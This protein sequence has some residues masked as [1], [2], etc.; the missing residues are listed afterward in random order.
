MNPQLLSASAVEPPPNHQTLVP[1]TPV[2]Q[3]GEA[4]ADLA[5]RIHAATYELLVMLREFDAQS[6]WNNG[7]MSC[8]HWLHWRTGI[9]L[10]AAREKVR[11]AKAVAQ[12][13]LLSGALQRGEI[14]YAKVRA[15]TRVATPENEARL[16]H[17]AYAG[18]AA[19]VERL[20][21][22]WRRCDRIMEERQ[23]ERA[24]LSRTVTTYVDED[25]MVVFRARLTPEL[26]AVVQRALEAAS[27]RLFQ[28]SRH[29]AAPES[30]TEEITSAQRRA[31]A[32]ALLAESALDNGLDRGTS[33][34]RYQVVMHVEG[35]VDA[36]VEQAVLE[37][38]DGGIHV[39]AETSRRLSCDAALVVMRESPDGSVLDVGRKTRTIPTAIRRALDARDQ[40]CRFPGCTASRCDAHHIEHWA[41]GGATAL[42]NL[43]LVCRRHHR[44]VHE[45]GWDVALTAGETTFI[46]PDGRPLVPAPASSSDGE[47]TV[48]SGV[49]A[50]SLRCW[51]G[52]RFNVGYAIDV[53]WSQYRESA[54]TNQ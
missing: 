44:L 32:L 20:A 52:T 53:L 35:P 54:H 33:A 42:D 46:R 38:A 22:A 34:D 3:L 25:G 23:V 11:V 43:V 12:L 16:L 9:D 50:R 26:G 41:D 29:A 45:G 14:S 1:S 8:A 2:E 31:D 10:G 48:N 15:L 47:L 39:S 4:I 40:R 51:D 27:E 7:F 28:E 13:P 19:Q 36:P 30:V 18:T 5:A 24:H 17:V 37:L 6:G 49:S 21:R